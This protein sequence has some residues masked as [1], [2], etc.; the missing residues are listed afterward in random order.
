VRAANIGH[1]PEARLA[2]D[3]NRSLQTISDSGD[4]AVGRFEQLSIRSRRIEAFARDLSNWPQG[5]HDVVR[6]LTKD[7]NL[8]FGFPR[9]QLNRY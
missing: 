5:A 1:T 9:H 8:I 4:V 3:S 6:Q 7:A 2:S